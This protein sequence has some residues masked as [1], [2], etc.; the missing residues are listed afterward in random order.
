MKQLFLAL[1]II[2]LA[3]CQNSST[4]S[5][6]KFKTI[7]IKSYGEVETLPDMATFRISL[8]CLN[9]SIKVS[10]K[11]LVDK[12]N[13]LIA[14]M[15]SFGIKSEDILTTS[16]EMSKSY[17]WANNS[18][19]FEGYNSSTS[20]FVTVKNIAK[21]DEIYTELLDNKNLDLGGLSYSH[22]M[23]DSLK[24]EAYLAALENA[25]TLSDKLLSKLPESKKEILKIGNVEL[26]ASMPEGL[27]MEDKAALMEMEVATKNRSVA[28]SKGTVVVSAVLFVEYQIK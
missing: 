27:E 4:N 11:C 17:R 25:N 23:L 18:Q 28:I 15:Q 13:E 24:N 22:S 1:S 21:L 5:P 16:V 12:S 20:L 3:A 2:L 9:M 26:S 7:M 14:K 6:T 19:V 10:K 8:N